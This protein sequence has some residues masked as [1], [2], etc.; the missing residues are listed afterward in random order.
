[1]KPLYKVVLVRTDGRVESYSASGDARATLCERTLQVARQLPPT[2]LRVA[3][4][5][6][7][8]GVTRI[9]AIFAPVNAI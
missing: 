4:E 1:M 9:A 7:E 5:A 2:T 3:P 6:Q 8:P